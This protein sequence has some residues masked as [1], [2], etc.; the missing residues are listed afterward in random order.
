MKHLIIYGHPNPGSFNHAILETL[1]RQLE[2]NGQEVRV[3]DIY[4]LKLDPFL[5]VQDIGDFK[6]GIYPEEIKKEHE[7]I[8]WADAI[9]F[10]YPIW[11]GGAPAGLKG[12][13]DRVF[14]D[15]FAYREDEQGPKGLLSDKRGFVLNTIA[16]PESVYSGSGM[17]G[18]MN[19][20]M[21]DGFFKFCSMPVVGH[22]YFSVI[23]CSE[24]ERQAM[25]EKVKK[26]ADQMSSRNS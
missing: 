1:S 15:G 25:L 3:R 7:H 24:A 9:F 2:K 18:S 23:A 8:R 19:Q 6:K 22:V 20:A 21:D 14:S 5:T 4:A 16:A 12:Y 26:I 17:F 13:I 11:W 10:I